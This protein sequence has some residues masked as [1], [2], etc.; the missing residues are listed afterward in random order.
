MPLPLFCVELKNIS[1][2]VKSNVEILEAAALI[3]DN[4]QNDPELQKKLAAFGFPPKHI[5]EGIALRQHALM[6]QETKDS[7]YNEKWA[8]SR[9][10]NHDVESVI[11]AFKNHVKLARIGYWNEPVYL[12]G[13][14]IKR[15]A[16]GNWPLIR[17]AQHFYTQL[18]LNPVPMEALGIVLPVLEQAQA[19]VDA[20]LETKRKRTRKKGVAQDSTREKQKAFQE[21]KAWVVECHK[22]IRF[23]FRDKP[24][25]LESFGIP[26]SSVK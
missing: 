19:G 17:Q 18:L 25:L 26:V 9:Q 11:G 14:K 22:A 5:Q 12:H 4:V 10:I 20:L 3:V 23:A 7:H 21:L 16:K 1:M 8:I 15:F 2:K 13:L 6:M 24:Q